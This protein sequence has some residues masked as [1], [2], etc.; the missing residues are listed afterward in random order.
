MFTTSL[1][2]RKRLNDAV[3][4]AFV[5]QSPQ[6]SL[7]AHCWYLDAL[8]P[9]WQALIVSKGDVWQAVMPLGIRRK[10]GIRYALQPSFCQYLG[11]LFAPFEGKIH[12]IMHRKREVLQSLLNAMPRDL[13]YWSY[14]FSPSF[15][16]FLPFSRRQCAITPRV[17][18]RLDLERPLKI[19]AADFS[20]SVTNHLKKARHAGLV[21]REGFD[22]APLAGQMRRF[23]FVRTKAEQAA[24]IR[25][26]QAARTRRQGFL[27]EIADAGGVVHCRGA[28]L[29]SAEK[30]VFV[31]SALEPACK[32][33]GANSLLVWRAIEHCQAHGIGELD[34]K[35]S[36]LAGVE[37][38]ILG[39]HPRQEVYFNITQNRLGPVGNLLYRMQNTA[40]DFVKKFNY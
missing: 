23:G 14:N 10:F 5:A 4:D 20:S 38:F 9:G 13:R 12:R 30:A 39:F 35:G 24:F 26:W 2:D 18:H 7:Y 37:H 29:T 31:A 11:V 27:L 22:I 36:M 28:F 8:I 21:C 6:G 19:I 17:N 15:D 16:Y 34:F 25:L 33:R 40:R 3:W 32:N 1:I